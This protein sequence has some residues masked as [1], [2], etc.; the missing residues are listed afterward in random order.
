MPNIIAVDFYRTGDL[1]TVVNALNGVGE[2]VPEG[3]G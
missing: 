1:L 3:A 2:A